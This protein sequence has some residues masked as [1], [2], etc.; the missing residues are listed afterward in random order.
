MNFARNIYLLFM[1]ICLVF[2]S[3]QFSKADALYPASNDQPYRLAQSDENDQKFQLTEGQI[4]S[5]IEH[6][7]LNYFLGRTVDQYI[8]FGVDD[9]VAKKSTK[10]LKLRVSEHHLFL[11]YQLRFE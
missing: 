7:L 4:R 8:D 5:R 6:K 3:I 11:V 9:D 10:H 1:W 2:I